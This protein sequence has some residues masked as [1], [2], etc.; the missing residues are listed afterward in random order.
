MF[1]KKLS[2]PLAAVAASIFAASAAQASFTATITSSAGGGSLVLTGSS[3]AP[4]LPG[5]LQIGPI[6]ETMNSF[7]IS[8]F[9]ATSNSP[10]STSE[11]VEV[12]SSILITNTTSSAETLTIQL[13]DDGFTAPTG[14]NLQVTAHGTITWTQTDTQNS[15]D[16]VTAESVVQ[17]NPVTG[18][19]TSNTLNSGTSLVDLSTYLPTA[20][21][22]LGTLGSPYSLGSDLTVHLNGGDAVTVVWYSSVGAVP[23]PTA[24]TLLGMGGLGALLLVGRRRK[25]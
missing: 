8:N 11:A 7:G 12:G 19:L 14:S 25:A 9:T 4:A 1:S 18:T 21:S 2:L 23:E 10:S 3:A 16:V 24:L 17:G 15:T 22:A 5:T 6:N 20:S 13:A